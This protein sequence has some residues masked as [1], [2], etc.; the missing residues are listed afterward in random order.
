MCRGLFTCGGDTHVQLLYMVINVQGLFTCGGDIH[1]LP[2]DMVINVQGRVYLC[3]VGTHI[4]LP[5]MVINM[6]W[7]I[8][9]WRRYSHTATIHS[10]NMQGGW[11][12]HSYMAT[13]QLL[14]YFHTGAIQLLCMVLTCSMVK[15]FPCGYHTTPTWYTLILIWLYG[16]DIEAVW[17]VTWECPTTLHI[18]AA[19]GS[20]MGITMYNTVA[21]W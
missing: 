14:F 9:M 13:I 11:W 4:Q 1:V 15:A 19:Y 5:Y 3:V 18:S 12:G 6:Q 2:P 17:Q 16:N 8:Y 20:C 10:T 21:V 7:S